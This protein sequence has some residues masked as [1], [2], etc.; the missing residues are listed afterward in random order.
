[1]ECVV[2]PRSS[3]EVVILMIPLI[4]WVLNLLVYPRMDAVAH[5]K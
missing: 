5:S 4:R 1:M 2:T 3:S